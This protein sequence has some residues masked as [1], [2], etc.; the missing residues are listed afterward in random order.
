MLGHASAAMTLDVYSGVFTDDLDA[1]AERL[2]DGAG[3]ASRTR[4]VA[5]PLGL[6]LELPGGPEIL[7]AA[8]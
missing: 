5:S 7:A 2:H 8:D 1:A 3:E 4:D 6:V